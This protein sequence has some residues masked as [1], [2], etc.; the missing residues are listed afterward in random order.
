VVDGHGLGWPNLLWEELPERVGTAVEH[1]G[2]R[3]DVAEE[4]NPVSF[5]MWNQLLL[6]Y[7]AGASV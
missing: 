5:P 2:L 6:S 7:G 3:A 1:S 4:T